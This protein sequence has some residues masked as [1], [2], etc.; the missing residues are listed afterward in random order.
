MLSV[1]AREAVEILR[2]V[3]V[4]AAG[5][6]GLK[7]LVL[8]GS[9]SRGDAH[10]GSDWDF[11]YLADTEYQPDG[12]LTRLILALS[13]DRV[14]LVNLATASGLLRYRAAREGFLVFER[15][16]G[17]FDRFRLAAIDFWCDMQS[18]LKAGYDRV[19]RGVSP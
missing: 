13:T 14:D 11:G 7:A 2:L 10:E 9:R 3:P 17:E 6:A 8:M 4:E 18:V 5:E 16:R 1:V 15:G 19:L 12:L